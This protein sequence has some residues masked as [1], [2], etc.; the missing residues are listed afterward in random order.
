MAMDLETDLAMVQALVMAPVIQTVVLKAL[1]V[2]L[3]ELVE[4][5]VVNQVDLIAPTTI[6]EILMGTKYY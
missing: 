3:M 1:V 5:P 2:T 4:T 6:Q